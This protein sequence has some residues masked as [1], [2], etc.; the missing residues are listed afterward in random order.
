M[1][2]PQ[3]PKVMMLQ[4]YA[5]TSSNYRNN[6]CETHLSHSVA[7]KG[8]TI[9]VMNLASEILGR[10]VWPKNNGCKRKNS[11]IWVS[12]G[13]ANHDQQEKKA[14]T[15]HRV[16]GFRTREGVSKLFLER[17]SPFLPEPQALGRLELSTPMLKG[18]DF[19]PKKDRIY[20]NS[21]KGPEEWP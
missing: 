3:F 2:T 8:G 6:I 20:Q 18:I 14:A 7:R 12:D 21:A 19:L 16:L 10:E 13:I 1:A 11:Q 5:C 4:C 15:R 9:V 17:S